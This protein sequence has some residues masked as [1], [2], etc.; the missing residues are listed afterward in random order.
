MRVGNSSHATPAR[1]F[2]KLTEAD[3]GK[4]KTRALISGEL[5]S[6]D[7][8]ESFLALLPT[9]TSKG[10]P[11]AHNSLQFKGFNVRLI[12]VDD[13]SYSSKPGVIEK[14]IIRVYK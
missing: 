14:W 1:Y 4:L 9:W 8:Y 10:K 2:T 11:E 13:N 6:N 7:T 12:Y 5:Y 3:I